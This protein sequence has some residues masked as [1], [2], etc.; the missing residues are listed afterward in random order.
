MKLRAVVYVAMVCAVGFAS[1]VL[2]LTTNAIPY[3]ESFEGIPEGTSVIDTNLNYGWFGEEGTLA[4][5]TNLDYGSYRQAPRVNYPITGPHASVLYFS[6]GSISNPFT[7]E[8]SYGLTNVWVDMMIRPVPMEAPAMTEAVSNSQLTIYVN[9]NGDLTV[10]HGVNT[11]G[12][13]QVDYPDWTVLTNSVGPIASDKWV[14]LTI[15][16]DYL[17]DP[18]FLRYFKIQLNGEEFVSERAFALPD[19][20]MTPGGPW[21]LCANPNQPYLSELALSGSGWVDDLVVTNAEPTVE[22]EAVTIT[23]RAHGMEP[24]YPGLIG[25]TITPS[26]TVVLAYNGSTNFFAQAAPT[27]HFRIYR[28]FT[29]VGG[30]ASNEVVAAS[31]ASDYDYAWL[32]ATA[33][34]TIDVYFEPLKT[35]GH[36]TPYWW[37]DLYGY[38]GDPEVDELDDSD[39]D[40]MAA[41]EEYLAGTSPT[42]GNSALRIISAKVHAGT[43]EVK[44]LGSS[45]AANPY[46]IVYST[47]LV[48]GAW[49]PFSNNIPRVSGTNVLTFPAPAQAPVFYNVTV[50]Y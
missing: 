19:G 32:N 39:G 50:P 41:W 37:L 21:F 26:G 38:T 7:Y 28:L 1:Q 47:N 16:M 3:A 12:F 15:T 17:S 9:T 5:V 48:V 46:A 2:G 27:N 49:L 24:A 45:T 42:D 13:F 25:G 18:N 36:Q 20:N 8:S 30:D 34:G 10:W 31:G 14:R 22:Y 35:T 11:S 40:G 33:D 43:A 4:I 23:A 44:W 6:S 29:R